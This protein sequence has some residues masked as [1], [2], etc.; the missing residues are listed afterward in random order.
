MPEGDSFCVSSGETGERLDVFLSHQMPD[1]SRS[2]IQRWIESGHVTVD[3]KPIQSKY[4]LKESDEV[5]VFPTPPEVPPELIPEPIP[6]KML[7]EDEP[8][9]VVNKRAGM[10]VH[11]GAGNWEGTLANA[12]LYHFRQI[13]HVDTV[14]PG[15]VHRL[16]KL[17]SGIMVVAKNE[18]AHDFL[19]QQFKRREV[20]KRYLVLVYGQLKELEGTIDIALGRHPRSRTRISTTS[21]RPRRAVTHY[22]VIR[23]YS[24]FSYVQVRPLTGRTHQIRVHLQHLGN[25]VVGDDTYGRK[26]LQRLDCSL[27]RSVRDL[28]RHFLHASFLS[29]LH[30]ETKQRVSFEAPLPPELEGFLQALE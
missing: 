4:R 3:G 10:V 12:L 22:R 2:T 25:P 28:R 13:S 24:N 9:V 7:Y 17:T 27:Q 1:V 30:P 8:L 26:A 19:A 23:R 11:P 20:K 21:R 29:F 15:I 5:L 14:R 18:R 16:D 6:L